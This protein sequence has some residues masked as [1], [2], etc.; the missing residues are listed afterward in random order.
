MTGRNILH[1]TK[2]FSRLD[3]VGSKISKWL[4]KVGISVFGGAASEAKAI[5][6][7]LVDLALSRRIE[8]TGGGNM[9]D[10]EREFLMRY[11]ELG[12]SGEVGLRQ[13]LAANQGKFDVIVRGIMKS[14]F[15]TVWVEL[16]K[17][18]EFQSLS[19]GQK[20]RVVGDKLGLSPAEALKMSKGF[21]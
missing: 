3:V 19:R 16:N 20:I 6:N 8:G 21:R 9:S 17:T 14:S 13:W 10:A 15:N 11:V 18:P 5:E 4:G 2:D 1:L 7:A 12:K